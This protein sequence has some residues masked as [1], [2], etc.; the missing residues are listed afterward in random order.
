MILIQLLPDEL[1]AQPACREVISQYGQSFRELLQFEKAQNN[2]DTWAKFLDVITNIRMR[3]QV[4]W[5]L[6]KSLDCYVVLCCT[7]RFVTLTLID[8]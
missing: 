6:D 4:K 2:A 7:N 8:S 5:D 1:L 3:H